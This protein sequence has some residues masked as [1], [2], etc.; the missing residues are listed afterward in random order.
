[1]ATWPSICMPILTQTSSD[2]ICFNKREIIGRYVRL[3]V[4]L[5]F[6]VL[7]YTEYCYESDSI[8]E[9]MKDMLY[10]GHDWYNPLILS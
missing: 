1:M 9:N 10:T 7:Q 6:P 4:S 5:D 2:N 8:R 3:C